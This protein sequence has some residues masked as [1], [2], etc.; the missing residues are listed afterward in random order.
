MGGDSWQKRFKLKRV[1]LGKVSL[2]ALGITQHRRMWSVSLLSHEHCRYFLMRV[3]GGKFVPVQQVKVYCGFG[4]GMMGTVL[5]LFL[6]L[7]SK[8]RSL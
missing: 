4:Q 8:T 1:E 6:G 3:G 2:K 5:M 7:P